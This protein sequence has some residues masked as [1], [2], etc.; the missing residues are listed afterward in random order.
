MVSGGGIAPHNID[1]WHA[2]KHKGDTMRLHLESLVERVRG[3]LAV[4][5]K[6]VASVHSSNQKVGHRADIL[7][8]MY[9]SPIEVVYKTIGGF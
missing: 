4:K 3:A 6:T 1:T 7:R 2:L 5:E 9:S 8:T